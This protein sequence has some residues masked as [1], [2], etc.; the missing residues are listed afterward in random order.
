MLFQEIFGINDNIRAL[1]ERLA[2]AGYVTVAPDMFWRIEPRFDRKDESSLAE[3]MSMVQR[4]DWVAAGNDI[5]STLTHL[6]AMP[7]CDGK[8]GG[9]GFCLGGTLAY[10]FATSARVQGEGPAAV[11]AYY[12]S[13]IHEMLD[14]ADSIECPMMFHYGDNDPFIGGE[15]IAAVEAAVASRPDI[16]FHHYAAGHAFSNWDAPSMYDKASADLAWE[17]S[18]EFLAAHLQADA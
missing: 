7:Q 16:A 13:G 8:V 17:R 10:V 4:L 2:E 1:A 6:L 3:C 5:T 12:G 11:V 18:L 9:I 14:Q 15:Q